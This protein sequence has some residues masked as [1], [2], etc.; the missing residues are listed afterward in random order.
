MLSVHVRDERAVSI[1]VVGDAPGVLAI[2]FVA[3]HAPAHVHAV[4]LH[5]GDHAAVQILDDVEA[6]R[7]I[8]RNGNGWIVPA[9]FSAPQPEAQREP[10]RTP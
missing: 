8:S 10:E 6:R 2:V 7:T 5:D 9:R 1:H 4:G 3:E